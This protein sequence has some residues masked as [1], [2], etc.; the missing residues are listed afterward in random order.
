MPPL[1]KMDSR[2]ID[3][4]EP[5]PRV[6]LLEDGGQI[7]LYLKHDQSLELIDVYIESASS[8]FGGG[9][10]S[11]GTG[12][13][14][15]GGGKRGKS[16]STSN[17]SNSSSSSS[18]NSSSTHHNHLIIRRYELNPKLFAI[19][20]PYL[21]KTERDSI[22]KMMDNNNKSADNSDEN[23][24]D[25]EAT[26]VPGTE[27]NKTA[28]N[29]ARKR[30]KSLIKKVNYLEQ[31]LCSDTERRLASSL[32]ELCLPLPKNLT[33]RSRAKSESKSG[34][35]KRNP[36]GSSS[37]SSS[38]SSALTE[39]TD[40]LLRHI[41]SNDHHSNA[42][43]QLF[44]S[45]LF[46]NRFESLN[47]RGKLFCNPYGKV[48]KVKFGLSN[49]LIP[50]R[51]S[52]AGADIVE[53][54]TQLVQELQLEPSGSVNYHLNSSR[55]FFVVMDPA[56]E[57]RSVKRKRSYETVTL[58]YLR[59]MCRELKVLLD[60]VSQVKISSRNSNNQDSQDNNSP[61]LPL[62]LT[63]IWTT[64]ADKDFVINEMLPLLG[65]TLGFELKWHKVCCCCFFWFISKF[66]N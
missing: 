13:S 60:M 33:K 31:N 45:E 63:A 10:S 4:T 29:R 37:A 3:P 9:G 26:E 48:I 28:L 27:N 52:F 43:A 54:I 35:R 6:M 30:K 56:W 12:A 62:I 64:K 24:D 20:E 47:Y 42:E 44:V 53:G 11:S 39:R 57:N 66:P 55:P 36:S 18:S 19:Q 65:L 7:G 49:Y 15:S 23:S 21:M 58:D 34:G 40:L 32:I 2:S 50:A 51:C 17:V 59:R 14:S 16:N 1:R 25:E 46:K 38:S 5:P 22:V 61:P 8:S 41:N